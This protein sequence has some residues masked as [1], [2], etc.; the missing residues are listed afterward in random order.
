MQGSDCN[1]GGCRGVRGPL[2]LGL[3][4]LAGFAFLVGLYLSLG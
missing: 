1:P 4:I 2:A 3:G